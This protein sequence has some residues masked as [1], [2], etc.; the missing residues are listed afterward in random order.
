MQMGPGMAS[1]ARVIEVDI[2]GMVLLM[3]TAAVQV[4]G[5]EPTGAGEQVPKRLLKSFDR[6]QEAVQRVAVSTARMIV[7]TGKRAARPDVVQIE[8][9]MKLSTKGD[10][11]IV[12]SSAEGSLKIILTY[13]NR[14]QGDLGNAPAN[15]E[16]NDD[17]AGSQDAA[18]SGA[19]PV[20]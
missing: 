10:V 4:P 2:D 19:E 13:H 16:D 20:A 5:W 12:G 9:G 14:A 8:L 11:I 7:E 17:L 15:G 18:A 1:A 3:E 6:L